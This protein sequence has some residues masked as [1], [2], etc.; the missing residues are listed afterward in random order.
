MCQMR[1]RQEQQVFLLSETTSEETCVAPG[2]LVARPSVH[3]VVWTPK[4]EGGD[5][6]T[7]NPSQ[8]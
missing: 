8:S 4:P 5:N 2:H 7:S 1:V 6:E 3:V